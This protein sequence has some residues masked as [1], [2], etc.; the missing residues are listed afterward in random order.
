MMLC[1][2]VAA[3]CAE[4]SSGETRPVAG[5]KRRHP[6]EEKPAS[7]KANKAAPKAEAG[8][9]AAAAPL[10]CDCCARAPRAKDLYCCFFI[11]IF[12]IYFDNCAC[13]FT[14]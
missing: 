12:N 7:A 6:P 4:F 5:M 9:A 8:S 2:N 13:L 3:F 11:F 10:A 1:R 14:L